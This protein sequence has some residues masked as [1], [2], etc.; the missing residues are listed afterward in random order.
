[1]S[2][3]TF[4]VSRT[5]THL[6]MTEEAKKPIYQRWW[7]WLVVVVAGV[8]VLY[9]L[10]REPAPRLP[11]RQALVEVVH[12]EL[13]RTVNW[14]DAPDR[15]RGFNVEQRSDGDYV[16]W[17]YLRANADADKD[18]TRQ[19]MLRDAQ[20][21]IEQLSTDAVFDSLYVYRLTSF[22]RIPDEQGGT[23]ETAAGRVVLTREAAQQIHWKTLTTNGFERLVRTE[24][25]LR[26]HSTLR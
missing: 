15:L 24:G 12:D 9:L 14:D 22:L 26:F 8:G 16:L 17:L 7:L 20:A 3:L 11:L 6:P 13:G 25:E 10:V 2:T 1:M 21:L 19:G 4:Y 18:R 23:P 5:L